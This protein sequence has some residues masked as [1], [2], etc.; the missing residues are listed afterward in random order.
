MISQW[1]GAYKI[2]GQVH[3]I[4]LDNDEEGFTGLGTDDIYMKHY[5]ILK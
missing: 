2:K 5:Q 4:M 1:K 3:V